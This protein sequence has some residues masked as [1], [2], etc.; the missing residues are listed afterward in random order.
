[1]V[2]NRSDFADF[3]YFLAIE[4]HRNFRLAGLELGVSASAL[5]HSLKGLE[6][7][8][9]VR[10]VNRTNRSVTLTAAGEALRDA[11]SQP[12]DRI[13]QAVETLNEFRDTPT[14]RI[15]LNVLVDAAQLLLAPLLSTFAD[16]YPEIQ[17]DIVASDRMVDI[18]AEG[19]DA[20][21][22]H[23]GT[24]PEDMITQR[25][26]AELRWGVVAS[27]SYLER[28]GAPERPE[29]LAKHRCMGFRLG[30]DRP[31]RWEFD[32]G[33]GDFSVTIADRLT[34]NDGRTML[35]FALSGVGLMYGNEAIFAPYV[36]RGELR[37]VLREWASSGSAYQI[38][39]S[40]RR[41]M[42][43]GLKLLIDLIR[44]VRPM[45]L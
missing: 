16:R 6:S 1:M 45:G 2:I 28:F 41:Q 31:Y 25:L 5:S 29:D 15:R 37:Y 38:Y 26:S 44:E 20:G 18:V 7:R 34:I 14:G 19:F 3:S 33:N 17:L 9:G 13:S 43:T 40:S 24:V 12:F 32:D 39:Y 4:R 23:G 30:D 35:A 27:P 21:I 11:I 22:R 42:P 8:L 36:E 10:L